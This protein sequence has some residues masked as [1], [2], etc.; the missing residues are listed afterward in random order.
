MKY[1]AF[2]S[3]RHETG[4]QVLARKLYELL[5]DKGYRVWFDEAAL[6]PGTIWVEE[7]KAAMLQSAAVLFVFSGEDLNRGWVQSELEAALKANKRIVP[8]LPSKTYLA[9]LPAELASRQAIIFSENKIETE[10]Q[11]KL[12]LKEIDSSVDIWSKIRSYI[13][14]DS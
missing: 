1:H 13:I 2:I 4:G 5:R 7:V 11:F 9:E 6:S 10:R 12:L 8:V 3:Y 14:N